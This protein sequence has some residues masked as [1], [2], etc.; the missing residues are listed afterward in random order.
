MKTS[1]I[2]CI[3][4]EVKTISGLVKSCCSYNPYTEVIVV[5]YGSVEE[6][7]ARANALKS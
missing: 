5:D 2:I 3:Y 4:N 1:I 7:E 6:I